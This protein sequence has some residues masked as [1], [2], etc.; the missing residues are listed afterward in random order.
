MNVSLRQLRAA[1]GVAQHGSFRR[2]AEAVHLS[3]PAL[4]LAISELEDALGVTLFDRTSRSVAVTEVGAFFVQGAIRV[5]SDFDQL[6]H[7]VSDV[8]QSRRGEVVVSCV[9]SIAGRIMP[10]ALQNCAE[11]YPQVDVTVHDD[12]AQQVLLA[13]R[14]R[15]AD[16]GITIAP[17]ELAEGMVFEPLHEDRF[18]LVCQ[19]NHPLAKRRWVAW[20]EIDG[21]SLISLSTN[22]GTHQMI[23]DELVRQNIQTA[24]RTPVSHLSTVHGMLEA[25]FGV[26]ILPVIALPVPG[27]PTLLTLPLVQP[28]M[29]RSIGVYYRRDRS[30]SP[31]AKAFLDVVR[32]V[33][34]SLPTDPAS[35][36]KR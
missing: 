27:H 22:S 34:R 18:H 25:G 15:E 12:V 29:S 5:L 14:T 13:V 26:A 28:E 21:E 6:L 7:D 24:R 30:F 9:S 31:A 3:Q 11:R 36:V 17:G 2:A 32:S 20:S 8:A 33:L 23:H 10:M 4:S 19:R 16:F 35:A 1:V